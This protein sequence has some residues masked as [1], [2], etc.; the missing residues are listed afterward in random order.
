M[1]SRGKGRT[2]PGDPWG[3]RCLYLPNSSLSVNI[4]PGG[5]RPAAW[6]PWEANDLRAQKAVMT[7]SGPNSLWAE[8]IL[9]GL[10]HQPSPR[11]K[12]GRCYGRQCS[13]AAPISNGV[14]FS[15]KYVMLRRK[16]IKLPTPAIPVTFGML[17]GTADQ[18]SMGASTG[19]HPCFLYRSGTGH[20]LGRL[21][22]ACRD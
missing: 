12:T 1:K 10:A 18:W 9:Q 6:Y 19:H 17:S 14:P 20:M 16:E 4:N 8:T 3:S 5:N 15:K 11:P 13:L 2:Y 7:E 22:E 21:E